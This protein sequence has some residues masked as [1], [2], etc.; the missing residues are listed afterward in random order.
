MEAQQEAVPMEIDYEHHHNM[1]IMN[2]FARA[3]NNPNLRRIL[4]LSEP[5]QQMDLDD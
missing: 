3:E 2:L 1:L 5:D 4:G